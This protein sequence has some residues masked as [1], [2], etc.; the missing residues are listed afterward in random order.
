MTLTK[1][2]MAVLLLAIT[3]GTLA[4]RFA[5]VG[6]TKDA[7]GQLPVSP[8]FELQEIIHEGTEKKGRRPVAAETA[9]PCRSVPIAVD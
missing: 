5:T 6:P 1:I 8:M 3:A 9:T 4:F 7:G 2:K